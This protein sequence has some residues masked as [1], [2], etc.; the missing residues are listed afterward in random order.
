MD[1]Y[2]CLQQFSHFRTK[3]LEKQRQLAKYLCRI[4]NKNH[5]GLKIVKSETDVSPLHVECV[6]VK[7]EWIDESDVKRQVIT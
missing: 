5:S 6:V 1:C 7:T 4:D 2:Q 3:V